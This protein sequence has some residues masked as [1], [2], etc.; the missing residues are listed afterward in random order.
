MLEDARRC[1]DSCTTFLSTIL[2]KYAVHLPFL[3]KKLKVV[4]EK[5]NDLKQFTGGYTKK[6]NA[7]Q[8][9]AQVS[10]KM[11]FGKSM[12]FKQIHSM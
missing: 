11:S 5:V 4:I 8:N 2:Y 7:L 10:N 6:Y 12:S 3:L 1:L 9:L